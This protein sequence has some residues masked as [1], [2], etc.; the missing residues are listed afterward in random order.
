M[1]KVF[2]STGKA[3]GIIGGTFAAEAEIPV[4]GEIAMGMEAAI[5]VGIKVAKMVKEKRAE[6]AAEEAKIE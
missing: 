6:K 1:S 5:L 3:V 4:L 2:A